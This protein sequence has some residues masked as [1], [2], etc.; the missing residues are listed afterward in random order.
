[1]IYLFRFAENSEWN[2]KYENQTYYFI[3]LATGL[4]NSGNRQIQR[5][6]GSVLLFTAKKTA[7]GKILLQQKHAIP[8][9]KPVYSIAPYG[10]WLV[11]AK[12][13]PNS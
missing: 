12:N 1:M 5:K 8:S 13:R 3:V 11:L 10:S 2:C 7:E 6:G 4:S 9:A